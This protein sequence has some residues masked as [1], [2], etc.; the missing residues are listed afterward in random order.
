MSLSTNHP[1]PLPP[2][3][4]AGAAGAQSSAIAEQASGDDMLVDHKPFD[5]MHRDPAT[6]KGTDKS[7]TLLDISTAYVSGNIGA[8]IPPITR[9]YGT[10]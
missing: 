3:T 5:N 2:S 4:A 8:H 10:G 7:R 1:L 6:D 9:G